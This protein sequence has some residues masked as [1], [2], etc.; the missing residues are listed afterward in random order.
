MKM[1][2][3]FF[4]LLTFLW[5]GYVKA[6]NHTVM[7][8]ELIDDTG[9]FLLIKDQSLT[10][11]S[12][13]RI[14]KSKLAKVLASRMDSISEVYDI[15]DELDEDWLNDKWYILFSVKTTS[16]Q[17]HTGF[18]CLAYVWKRRRAKFLNLKNCATDDANGAQFSDDD[19][20]IVLHKI[21]MLS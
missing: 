20:N 15:S 21:I 14:S 19:I 10:F 6:D 3:I 2:L 11:G 7:H 8:R 5:G 18:R 1:P 17:I 4:L 13:D 9:D 16:G 12:N